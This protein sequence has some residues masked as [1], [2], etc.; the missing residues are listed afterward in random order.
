[1]KINILKYSDRTLQY[2]IKDDCHTSG[3][4][5]GGILQFWKIKLGLGNLDKEG[6]HC[7]DCEKVARSRIKSDYECPI[8][9]HIRLLFDV[10]CKVNW[11]S[12]N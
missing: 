1:M 9:L 6:M 11:K 12:W 3:I 10:C 5:N 8:S 7:P 2:Q 4:Q